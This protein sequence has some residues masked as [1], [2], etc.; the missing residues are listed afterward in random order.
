MACLSP[1]APNA[2]SSFNAAHCVSAS[3][4]RVSPTRDTHYGTAVDDPYRWLE[5]RSDPAVRSWSK[6]QSACT[7]RYL[8]ALPDAPKIR[9]RLTQ[10]LTAERGTTYSA[11]KYRGGRLFV[12]RRSPEDQQPSLVWFAHADASGTPHVVLDPMQFDPS[13]ETSIDWYVPS[14]DGELV[15]I[16]LSSGGSEGGT[17]RIF[18]AG[19]GKPID[20]S[21]I[22]NV[23]K[24][25]ASGDLAWS[26]DGRGFFYT[27][28]PRAN[29]RPQSELA[30]YQQ[31]YYHQLGTAPAA[32]RYELGNDLP[33]IAEIRL[34]SNPSSGQVIARV[35][36]G[37]SGQFR[38]FLREA[39]GRWRPFGSFA[40]GHIEVAFGAGDDLF[41]F[42]KAGA[43]RGKVIRLATSDLNLSR[44]QTVI[45]ESDAA[46]EHNAYE[47]DPPTI[48]VTE[49]ALVLL[50]QLGGPTQLRA[51]SLDGKARRGPPNIP[52]SHVVFVNSLGGDEVL[53]GVESF[54]TPAS[55]VRYNARTAV[56]KTLQSIGDSSRPW[57]DV[58]VEREFAVSRDGT[59]V[60]VSILRL[61]GVPTRG[62]LLTGYGG[63]NIAR[64]PSFAPQ[65]RV[66]LEQGIAYAAANLRGGSEFGEQWHRQG[67]LEQKQN[68]F[69]DF[70]A[71]AQHLQ[72]KGYA[73]KDKLAI[74]G[75]S[76]GGLLMGAVLTQRPH[77]IQAVVSKVGIYDSL[78]TE[79]DPNGAFNI[80]EYGSVREERMFRALRAYSPYHNVHDG[81]RYPPT[82]LLTGE[83]DNRVNP[84]HSR[85]MIARLQ[86]ANRSDAP[87]LL[88][89]SGNTG[90]G[91]GTPTSAQVEQL[92]DEYS[93]IM[94][95]LDI[96]YRTPGT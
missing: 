77:L 33:A 56:A 94:K 73:P 68:V 60:P 95:A 86:A 12:M 89:T 1:L 92:T 91:D 8:D 62:L 4:T 11:P 19:S 43:P 5:D 16:S 6:M 71:V 21:A 27:R 83:N 65:V 17:L 40:D 39:D 47:D 36:N 32:D 79:L 67:M 80:P 81:E 24:A 25:T 69:A 44:A 93:F 57:D 66:L 48:T 7:R 38:F 70:I 61:R 82:L 49:S 10:L 18:K 37:D 76:N 13:G 29:E 85:K 2:E 88:R 64:L 87:L 58:S 31:V 74:T 3:A 15:A 26:A 20:D 51:Y 78:R 53:F 42:T 96:P 30:L 41:V 34:S 45:A 46:L 59:R 84:M 14:D 22:E 90:H 23:S 72:D 35:Q 54:V 63:F 9:A 50:Y 28:Y 75:A 52:D 55:W